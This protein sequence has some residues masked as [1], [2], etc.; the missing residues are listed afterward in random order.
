MWHRQLR[1]GPYNK[2]LDRDTQM[3]P[4]LAHHKMVSNVK[5]IMGNDA[6]AEEKNDDEF[7]RSDS[8]NTV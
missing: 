6:E 8:L 4:N 3:C 2:S 5:I 1:L 7:G